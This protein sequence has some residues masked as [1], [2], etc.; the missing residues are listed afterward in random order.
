MARPGVGVTSKTT[1]R[2]TKRCR[3]IC[4]LRGVGR[5]RFGGGLISD[6][7]ADFSG[8]E[9]FAAS[10]Y[11]FK[12]KALL[13]NDMR[14]DKKSIRQAPGGVG[15]S[16]RRGSSAHLLTKEQDL[17]HDLTPDV[18]S[19]RCCATAA[20]TGGANGRSVERSLRKVQDTRDL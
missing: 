7:C 12:Y 15:W 13:F 20:G 3:I 4:D 5:M 16:G 8:C 10:F 11:K 2:N 18:T 1:K 6:A 19:T 17:S 9:R 14:L